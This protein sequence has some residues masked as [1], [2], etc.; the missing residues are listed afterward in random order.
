[1]NA[2]KNM[3]YNNDSNKPI[4]G[5][6]CTLSERSSSLLDWDQPNDTLWPS[7]LGTLATEGVNG[8]VVI[9]KLKHEWFCAVWVTLG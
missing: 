6:I 5:T 2:M 3:K 9:S 1:M 8:S 4:S 7:D